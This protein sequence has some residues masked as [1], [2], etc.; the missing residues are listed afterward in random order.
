MLLGAIADD[1]TGATDLARCWCAAACARCNSSACHVAGEA[2]PDADAVVVALKSRTA[3]ARQ[4][5]EESLAALEWLRAARLRAVLLQVLLDVR[6][7]RRRQYRAGRRRADRGIGLR[8]RACVP[9]VPSERPQ[10]LP[11]PSVRRWRAAERE[12]HGAPSADADDRRQSG[13]RAVATDRRHCGPGTVS[14]PSS[15]AL[16]RSVR[17]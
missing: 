7:H 3:P 10:R 4:A 12:R 5:V 14:R 9:G 11:G 2:A 1:F 16:W 8:L 13:A 15:R 6:Q 17:R